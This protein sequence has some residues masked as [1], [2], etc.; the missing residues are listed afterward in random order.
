MTHRQTLARWLV[1]EAEGMNEE[2]QAGCSENSRVR[3]QGGPLGKRTR[4]WASEVNQFG[5]RERM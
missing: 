3:G 4:E 1:P 5:F 2:S